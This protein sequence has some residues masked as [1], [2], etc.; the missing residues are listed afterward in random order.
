MKLTSIST[1]LFF[2]TL[3][4]FAYNYYSTCTSKYEHLEI[5]QP[6]P[7]MCT[8]HFQLSLP[9]S[10]HYLWQ[11]W[12]AGRFSLP[13]ENQ[14]RI[15]EVKQPASTQASPPRRPARACWDLHHVEDKMKLSWVSKTGAT[16]MAPQMVWDGKRQRHGETSAC[17]NVCAKQTDRRWR[18]GMEWKQSETQTGRQGESRKLGEIILGQMLQ[19]GHSLQLPILNNFNCL[20]KK[21]LRHDKFYKWLSLEEALGYVHT[22]RP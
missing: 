17:E 7:R 15:D 19:H 12:A 14:A 5:Y 16:E 4:V 11:R 21:Y 22:Y 8:V 6:R 20:N 13:W 9:Q 2:L 10:T 3:W 1:Q 18:A